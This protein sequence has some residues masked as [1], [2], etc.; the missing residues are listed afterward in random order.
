MKPVKNGPLPTDLTAALRRRRPLAR[1]V[2]DDSKGTT[3]LLK[4]CQEI[5]ADFAFSTVVGQLD[6]NA[7]LPVVRS[8]HFVLSLINTYLFL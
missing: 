2:V 1:I 6:V 4:Q 5:Q 8:L 3:S 7:D